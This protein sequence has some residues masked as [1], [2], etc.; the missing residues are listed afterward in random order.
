M[1]SGNMCSLPTNFGIYVANS[2]SPPCE[3]EKGF[4]GRSD[5]TKEKT[6]SICAAAAAA[7]AMQP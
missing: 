6:G 7:K 2:A 3:S 4:E 1:G 5:D